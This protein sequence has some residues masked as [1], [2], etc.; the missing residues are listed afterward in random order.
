MIGDFDGSLCSSPRM[1]RPAPVRGSAGCGEQGETSHWRYMAC[2]H[3]RRGSPRSPYPTW[4]GTALGTPLF[5]RAATIKTR[6]QPRRA[7]RAY[8]MAEI[9]FGMIANVYFY[10]SPV[11]FI[12]AYFLT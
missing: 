4:T 9:S 6:I 10:L 1:A 2:F 7:I 12:V 3:D 8:T 5:I 11:T